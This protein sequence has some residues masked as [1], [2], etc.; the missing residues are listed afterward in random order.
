MRFLKNQTVYRDAFSPGGD[1]KPPVSWDC[2]QRRKGISPGFSPGNA[3]HSKI[4]GK[5]L[6]KTQARKL[7]VC[8]KYCDCCCG[9][10]SLVMVLIRKT[11]AQSSAQ[12]PHSEDRPRNFALK[13]GQLDGPVR[14][15]MVLAVSTT[16][17]FC[18][19]WER[20]VFTGRWWKQCRRDPCS[21]TIAVLRRSR[22]KEGGS[23]SERPKAVS[24][25][26]IRQSPLVGCRGV[27]NADSGAGG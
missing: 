25:D 7:E 18:T 10:V 8:R 26:E 22:L 14:R 9:H 19:D 23:L 13:N 6:A 17:H 3:P 20:A 15:N 5:S 27:G 1:A 11:I 16:C 4:E 21:R 2:I 24:V 12:P